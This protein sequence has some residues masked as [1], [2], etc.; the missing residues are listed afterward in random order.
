MSNP[1]V[2]NLQ[3][4]INPKPLELGTSSFDTMATKPCVLHDTCFM[5][6][7][8]CQVSGV[9]C[10]VAH[11]NCHMS[12]ATCHL[13][14]PNSKARERRFT[15]SH[16]SPVMFHVSCVTCQMSHLTWQMSQLYFFIW[17]SGE[18]SRWRVCSQEGLP[19]LG[20]EDYHKYKWWY[21]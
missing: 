15:S 16:M 20:Y 7:V 11:V 9:R 4:I 14:L 12:G 5:S 19:R 10:Q 3:N 21:V 18:D 8:A 1:F 2:P 13:K 17:Q 6:C